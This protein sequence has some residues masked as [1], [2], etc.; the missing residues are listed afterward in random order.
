VGAM[1]KA[2]IHVNWNKS[3]LK[4][5]IDPVLRKYENYLRYK[6]FRESSIIRYRDLIKIYLNKTKS[7]KPSIDNAFEFRDELLKSNLK[8]STINLYFATMKQFYKMHG[9]E[10]EFPYLPVNNKLPYYLSS[11]DIL[12]ILSIISNLKHYTMISL[13]FYCMLRASE[14]TNLNDGDVDLK[15]LI[16]RVREG[17]GGK[18]A[19]LPIAPD[20][21]EILR[22]YLEIRP[23]VVLKDGSTPFFPTDFY[24][25]WERRDLYRM[26]IAYK[27]KANINVPGGTHLLR[28][29][30]ATI[31]LNNGADLLTVKTL[32]RHVSLSTTERY[33]H[34]S[35]EN[36]RE[37][38]ER[39]L[40]L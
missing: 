34:L 20:C 32:L 23:K 27:R 40:V 14:L 12:K 7:I 25:R 9:E 39:Y 3:Q 22:Q 35:K 36:I 31:L 19:L 26:F 1:K 4:N 37:K 13:C 29:S 28:H 18:D 24:N 38:Y 11:D 21:A 17:K 15:N 30:A 8:S 16:L 5:D 33:I 10:I 2:M 6:G